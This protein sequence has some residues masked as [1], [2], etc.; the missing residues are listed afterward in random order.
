MI[1]GNTNRKRK[2]LTRAGSTPDT[3][4]ADIRHGKVFGVGAFFPGAVE[5]EACGASNETLAIGSPSN[6]SRPGKRFIISLLKLLAH[7]RK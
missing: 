4:D 5:D 1:R 3:K 7:M 2:L 6:I